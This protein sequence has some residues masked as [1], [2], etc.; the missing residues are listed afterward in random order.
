MTV[1]TKRR[2]APEKPRSTKRK[3][4]RSKAKTEEK[5]AAAANSKQ[6]GGARHT[7][8]AASMLTLLQRKTGASIPELMQASGWQAHS[9]RGFL[10]GTVGKRKDLTLTSEAIEFR[11]R[12]RR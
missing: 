7:T 10:S 6:N 5:P 4:P 3:P 11:T 2:D 9:V 1:N 12:L 8:K